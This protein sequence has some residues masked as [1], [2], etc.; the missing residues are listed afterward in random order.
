MKFFTLIRAA[1]GQDKKSFQ[2]WFVREHAPM[3]L[4]HARRLERYIVNLAD[5]DPP[6]VENM[7]FV[8]PQAAP[9]YD[10]ITEMWFGSAGDF[11]DRARLFGSAARADAIQKHL[12]AKAGSAFSYRVTE[13][14]GKDQ[15]VLKAGQR[16]P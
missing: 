13:I 12:A 8:A 3:V 5:T 6:P 2:Q 4:E 15:A 1:A 14:V 11:K 9:S 7:G 16:T 10:V